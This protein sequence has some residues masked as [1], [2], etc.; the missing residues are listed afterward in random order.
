MALVGWVSYARLIRAQILVLKTA[1]YAVA[2]VSLGFGRAADHVPP[3]AAER[4]RR[5]AR[6]RHVRR[7]ARAAE[8]RGDQLPRP[9]RAAADRRMGRDGRRGPGASSPR[10]GGSRSS[11]ASPS[12][13]SP[14]RFS[15]L[16]D[17]L[18][19]S[20][21]CTNDRAAALGPRPRGRLQRPRRARAGCSTACPSTSTAARSSASSARA[22]RAR[23]C[24]A[25]RW[26]A[27]CRR[28]PCASPAARCC[29]TGAT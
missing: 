12:S 7:G 29:S 25:G 6:L 21:A 2:A 3:P 1:D 16:G 24:S 28:R 15:L 11:P 9:R 14:S 27:C 23:A 13:R 18:A 10:P 19:D 17:G 22:A 20:W 8:R 5:L 4:A 26:S